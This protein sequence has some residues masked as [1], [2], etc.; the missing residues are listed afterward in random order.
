MP[1]FIV[2]SYAAESVVD[3]QRRRAQ[4]AAQLKP[5]V[6]YVRTTFLP[7]DE[8]VLHVFEAPS[9]E[10]LHQAARDAALTCDRITEAVEAATSGADADGGLE[11]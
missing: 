1:T 4:L 7:T 9:A 10:A 8:T 5:G 3:A 6:R 11:R 2:E